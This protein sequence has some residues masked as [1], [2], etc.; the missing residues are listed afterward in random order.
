MLSFYGFDGDNTPIIKGSATGALAG[1]D[2]WVKAV[3][4]FC[5]ALE[6][7][8]TRT[9]IGRGESLLRSQDRPTIDTVVLRAVARKHDLA[10]FFASIPVLALTNFS[11]ILVIYLAPPRQFD[12]SAFTSAHDLVFYGAAAIVITFCGRAV[13]IDLINPTANSTAKSSSENKTENSQVLGGLFLVVIVMA[14]WGKLVF[15]G[16]VRL[17]KTLLPEIT[18]PIEV[19]QQATEPQKSD[20]SK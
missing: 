17:T 3:E 19:V 14:V 11:T 6:L 2:K 4:E 12:Q 8:N 10:A 16:Q 1:E 7:K 13:M 18:H 5:G 15:A 9:F 20:S